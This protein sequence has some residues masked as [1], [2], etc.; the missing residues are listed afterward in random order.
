ML[1]YGECKGMDSKNKTILTIEDEELIRD[2]FRFYLE[3]HGYNVLEAENGSAGL[4]MIRIRHP[5]LVLL[6]LRMPKMDGLEV[7]K[8]LQLDTPDLPVIVISGTG[9]IGD[10]AEA[11]KCGACNYLIKPVADFDIMRYAVEQALEKVALIEENRRLRR[12]ISRLQSLQSFPD[13]NR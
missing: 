10:V 4:E 2:S 8:Q 11:M 3:D 13:E 12:E 5:D 9:F 6:D 1:L 7:L